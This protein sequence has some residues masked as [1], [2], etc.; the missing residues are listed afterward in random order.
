MQRRHRLAVHRDAE[1]I[2]L[3]RIGKLLELE[4]PTE[5]PIVGHDSG[6]IATQH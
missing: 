6:G 5:C 4:Q 2:W 1:L 3:V